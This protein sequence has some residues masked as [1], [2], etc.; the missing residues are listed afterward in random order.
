MIA[1]Q[2]DTMTNEQ[3]K[4][5]LRDEMP[6][7][8]TDS[9]VAMLRGARIQ[10]IASQVAR[11]E[12]SLIITPEYHHAWRE[13]LSIYLEAEDGFAFR[14]A[15]FEK[16]K[17]ADEEIE[18]KNL[19]QQLRGFHFVTNIGV[20]LDINTLSLSQ[21]RKHAATIAENRRL[22]T[23]SAEEIRTDQSA[24]NPVK[25]RRL[26]G[27]PWMPQQLVLP[28]GL[29]TLDGG[30]SNGIH[31]TTMTPELIHFYSRS[32]SSSAEWHFYKFRL[33]RA[34]GSQQ[35]NERTQG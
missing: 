25:P 21:L 11:L 13:H 26:D 31:A 30:E 10:D 12:G 15:F 32:A 4:D 18:L 7:L 35:I 23:M 33:V 17:I 8:V 34:Y 20:R 29:K 22:Q 2:N 19:R 5:Y 28:A 1:I 6:W 3:I 9:N 27:M 16:K 14:K 24:K